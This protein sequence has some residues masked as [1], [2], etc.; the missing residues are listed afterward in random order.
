MFIIA[1]HRDK[2]EIVSIGQ[3]PKYYNT[4]LCTTIAYTTR[5]HTFIRWINDICLKSC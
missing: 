1:V 4:H 3:S 2:H 5:R